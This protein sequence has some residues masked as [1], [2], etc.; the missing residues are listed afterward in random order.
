VHYLFAEFCSVYLSYYSSKKQGSMKLNNISFIGGMMM[1][2]VTSL[3]LIS[4]DRE[5]AKLDR[6]IVRISDDP[7]RLNPIIARST[8]AYQI[9]SKIFQAPLDFDPVTL[10]MV[11][12]LLEVIPTLEPISE[13]QYAGYFKADVRILSGASWEDG[14]LVTPEDLEFT[15]KTILMCEWYG[16]GPPGLLTTVAAIEPHPDPSSATLI[17][18]DGSVFNA[19]NVLM[20]PVLPKY[21]FDP[22][23]LTND[24]D[25]NEALNSGSQTWLQKNSKWTDF[26]E[27]FNS[28]LYSREIISGSGPYSFAEW[29]EGQFVALT[30]KA[31]YWGD[32]YPDRTILQA[33]PGK[34]IYRIIPDEVSALESLKEGSVDIVGDFSPDQFIQL[35]E[36]NNATV[37]VYSPDVLQYYYTALNNN[38]SRLQYPE[39]RRALAHLMP[40]E[41]IIQ[42]LFS[43]LAKPINS[44][45]H[46]AKPYYNDSL[47][48]IS[49]DPSLAARILEEAGWRD[50]DGNGLLDKN[51]DGEQ[52]ELRFT[53]TTSQR[54]LGQDL[55]LIFQ[56]E[57]SKIGIRIDIDVVDNP[58][59]LKEVSNRTFQMVNLASRFNPGLDEVYSNWHSQSTGPSGNNLSGFSDPKADSLI[60]QIQMKKHPN[61]H[62]F[63]LYKELQRIIYESN[64]VLFICA[65]QER[66]A[67]RSDIELPLTFMKPG[68]LEHLARPSK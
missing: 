68:Y 8:I 24:L 65:P 7:D 31:N 28:T 15:L 12:V 62:L 29:Q 42:Q 50:S 66:I 22:G 38:D 23:E 4:C 17:L 48:S 41:E 19:F 46:P 25:I 11:P 56:E 51:I 61:E 60:L 2:V 33:Y 16:S 6:V 20:M 54:K 30:K 40:T 43:G 67:A 57:A 53:L 18:K 44:P 55:S 64:P 1:V 36:E 3:F 13:G 34:I 14:S 47:T 63:E 45:I 49:Y 32:R 5:E 52:L 21:I 39:V 10:Q 9:M 35:R 26:V 59:L 37:S 27:S 58:G